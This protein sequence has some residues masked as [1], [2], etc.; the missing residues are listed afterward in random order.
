[1]Q[2]QLQ[3]QRL[4]ACPPTA[5]PMAPLAS[6]GSTLSPFG[7][8]A[9]VVANAHQSPCADLRQCEA[10]VP[11]PQSRSVASGGTRSADLQNNKA[12]L[13]PAA[14]L[15]AAELCSAPM[16]VFAAASWKCQPLRLPTVPPSEGSQTGSSPPAGPGPTFRSC[17]TCS[18][19]RGA[20]NLTR[21]LPSPVCTVQVGHT[22][23]ESKRSVR[24]LLFFCSKTHDVWSHKSHS[25]HFLIYTNNSTPPCEV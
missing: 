4:M 20:N 8:L 11:W 14:P 13:L 25:V 23:Q 2:G 22:F 15:P 21:S 10:P 1:M 5:T 16:G 7:M 24:V 12:V 3:G 6:A 18:G 17:P 9:D 19:C